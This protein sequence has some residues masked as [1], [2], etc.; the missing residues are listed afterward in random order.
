MSKFKKAIG[1]S[2]YTK[3]LQDDRKEMHE[4]SHN[5]RFL[6]KLGIKVTSFCPQISV[7]NSYDLK[8]HNSISKAFIDDRIKIAL[9][10]D[11]G[12]RYREWPLKNFERLISLLLKRYGER[13][14]LFL[15]AKDQS[16]LFENSLDDILRARNVINLAGQTTLK[17]FVSTI[18]QCSII[19]GHDSASIHIAAALDVPSLCIVGGGQFGSFFPYPNDFCLSRNPPIIVY[20]RM[21]CFGCNW[22]CKYSKDSSKAYPCISEVSV[23]QVYNAV[24]KC[25]AETRPVK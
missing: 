21:E 5:K 16:I 11:S 7:P 22:S 3:L 20:N 24:E 4:L 8:L 15:L 19:I 25:L 9:S 14:V 2:Y 18:K 13:V 23:E 1:N 10:L 17:E 6:E 12:K